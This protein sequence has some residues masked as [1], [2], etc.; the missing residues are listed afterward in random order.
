VRQH[1]REVRFATDTDG[2]TRKES[3]TNGVLAASTETM[4]IARFRVGVGPSI[5]TASVADSTA[6]RGALP[7][8][9]DLRL[10]CGGPEFAGRITA[11]S[12]WNRALSD[13]EVQFLLA[14]PSF[15]VNVDGDGDAVN[16]RIDNCVT[17]ANAALGHI[18][19]P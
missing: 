11:L 7:V 13:T 9:G 8:A 16:D 10:V 19:L 14:A 3:K 18:T 6:Q 17:V 15:G 2:D 4:A 12:I 1:D 5:S